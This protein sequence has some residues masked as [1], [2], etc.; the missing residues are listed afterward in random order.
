[1]VVVVV[2]VVFPVA[3]VFAGELGGLVGV[4]VGGVR[5]VF[6]EVVLGVM[7][8]QWLLCVREWREGGVGGLSGEGGEE[9]REGGLTASVVGPSSMKK[10]SSS[11]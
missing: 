3:D 5:G 10:K 9:V 2:G 11:S 7:S 6:C 4:P 1:M 8:G